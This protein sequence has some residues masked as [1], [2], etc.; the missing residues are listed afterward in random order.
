MRL[1]FLYPVARWSPV[2]RTSWRNLMSA[3]LASPPTATKFSGNTKLFINGEWANSSDGATFDTYN[4]S[5]GET[6][7]KVAH[8]TKDD[9][10]RAVKSARKALEKGPWGKMDACDRGKLMFKLVDS[11]RSSMPKNWLGWNR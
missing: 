6:I 7:A 11:D 1:V 10:D 9:V 5:T 2:Y 3:A 8:A 4:P